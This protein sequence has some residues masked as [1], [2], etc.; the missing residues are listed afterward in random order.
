MTA[1]HR[2]LVTLALVG[3]GCNGAN[4]TPADASADVG[5]DEC[6]SG[7]P[8]DCTYVDGAYENC[9]AEGGVPACP[10]SGMALDAAEGLCSSVGA[11]CFDCSEGAGT[12]C[13]CAYAGT[14]SDAGVQL[15]CLGAGRSCKGP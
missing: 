9:G 12:W 10:S 15:K 11:T 8:C 7:V 6:P 5:G 13:Y 1:L 2:A 3:A 14:G 4:G